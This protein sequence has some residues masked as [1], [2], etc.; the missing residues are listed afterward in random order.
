MH[1]LQNPPSTGVMKYVPPVAGAMMY[2]PQRWHRLSNV[3]VLV[4]MPS[5]E[6]TFPRD[7]P[8]TK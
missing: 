3:G 8:G 1:C 7:S 5:P 6:N 4:F 2:L